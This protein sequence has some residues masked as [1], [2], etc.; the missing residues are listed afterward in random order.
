L[1]VS[2]YFPPHAPMGAVRPGKLQEYWR[3]AGFDVRTIAIGIPSQRV[4]GQPDPCGVHYVPFE[5]PGRL[6][7]QLKSSLEDSWMGRVI[8]RRPPSSSSNEAHR[9]SAPTENEVGKLGLVDLY[10]QALS[11]PDRYR[12]W[13]KPATELG[14]SWQQR[15]RPDL[16]YSSGPP[17][18]GHIVAARLSAKFG[19]PW[20]AELRDLW[21]G[22]PYFD[23]HRLVKPIH[24]RLA[25]A[26]LSRAAGCVVVTD[27]S[28]T[29]LGAVIRKPIM[30]SYNGYD[31]KDFE[32][33]NE[34]EP[35]DRERL[36]IVHA[37]I[38]YPGR[39]DPTPLFKAIAA[40][41]ERAR[42]IRCLFFSD[43]NGSVARLIQQHRVDGCVEI[44]PEVPRSEILRVERAVDVLLECRWQDSAGDGVI[45]GKLFEY[46]GARR[47]V[48]SLGSLTGEAAQIVRE[49]GFG[50]ASNDP[51][52]IRATLEQW[53]EIKARHG[54]L[55]DRPAAGDDRFRRETQFQKINAFINDLL[56]SSKPQNS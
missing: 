29:R 56:V 22:D 49:N 23:H 44:L 42:K 52:E 55:P 6:V 38:I 30:L 7:T 17:H 20:V 39:R 10:R 54:R 32:G 36:T 5:A 19:V 41:G 3:N 13:I 2:G 16:I 18:S 48:L 21:V 12:N 26:T 1:F 50:L 53:L 33:L 35:F 45:P 11:I 51:E 28:R 34:V 37:G 9:H 40:L 24:D 8:S 47:P 31:P 27:A 25:K 4:P 15:W 43:S 46:I 14:L